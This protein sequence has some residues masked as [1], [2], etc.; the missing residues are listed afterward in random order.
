MGIREANTRERDPRTASHLALV[1]ERRATRRGIYSRLVKPI[2]DRSFGVLLF[3]LL[4]PVMLIAAVAVLLSMGAPVI[5]KQERIGKDGEPFELYKLRT[6][7]PDRR[8]D[9]HEFTGPERR[10]VH[11]TRNDPRV[12]PMGKALRSVRLDELPQLWNV[13]RG[14]MSL[15]GP[16]PELPEIV[17]GYE[18][19]Q[20]ERHA[21]KPGV[22]GLWQVTA[23][24]GK[25]MHECV[26]VD[27]EYID[28]IRFSKD[29]R[30]LAQTPLAMVRRRGF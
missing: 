27:L 11:K 8:V 24:D 21:V 19:W 28:D 13:I 6:M 18:E 7:L 26:E 10:Q 12:L 3:I 5:Y 23:L 15:V 16:R 9:D 20:H 25:L 30:I 22:T 1:P 17:D 4:S 29:L 14:D 2:M